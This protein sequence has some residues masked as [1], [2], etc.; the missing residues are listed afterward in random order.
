M[1][2]MRRGLTEEVVEGNL[3]FRPFSEAAFAED[4]ASA[5]AVIAGGGFTLLGEAIYL[6]KPLLVVPVEGQFEQHMNARYVQKL[7]YGQC[8][9][10][11]N[12]AAIL[13]SFEANLSR[14]EDRLA[15]YHQDGNRQLLEALDVRLAETG[16]SSVPRVA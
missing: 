10:S 13:R 3:R 9:A 15:A 6:R 12:D 5:R 8:E 16:V 14:C 2:M 1:L 4:L 7:G 11:L